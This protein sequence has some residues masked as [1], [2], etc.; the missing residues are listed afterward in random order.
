MRRSRGLLFG[1]LIVAVCA[2]STGCPHSKG[3]YLAP[4]PARANHVAAHIR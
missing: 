2:L 3:G 4:S 1:A